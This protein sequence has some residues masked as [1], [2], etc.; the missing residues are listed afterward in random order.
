MLH[1]I[2]ALLLACLLLLSCGRR[3]LPPSPDR[4]APKLTGARGVDRN[5]VE[6]V[7]SEEMDGATIQQRKNYVIVNARSDTL[8]IHS[9]DLRPKKQ[10]ASLT[11]EDQEPISYTVYVSDVTDKAG[12]GLR[13]RSNKSF[14]GSSASDT[15][16]PWVKEIYPRDA[17]T[18]VAAD[19]ALRVVFSET[20]DTSS[21]SLRAG[22]IVVLPPPADSNWRWNEQMTAIFIPVLT[23][24]S[25]LSSVCATR[26]CADYSGN[27][28]SRL[29]RSVFTMLDSLPGGRISGRVLSDSGVS[30]NV[31]PVGVFDSLWIPLLIDFVRD[32]AGTYSFGLLSDG[33]YNVAAAADGDGDG[34]F[35]LRGVSNLVRIEASGAVEDVN[36]SL[37]ADVIFE[38][39]AEEV[40]LNFYKMNLREDVSK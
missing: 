7:F 23:L 32:T 17:S 31:N 33:V 38:Q 8:K 20:M 4:W 14:V 29:E 1:R 35:D 2:G 9:A 39:R 36:I 11:T 15:T 24:S 34:E 10:K 19:T 37:S 13:P 6:L 5:H 12:N 27:R 16:R 40:L 22:S 18:G 3:G 21:A 30:A 28:L 25:Y 26:G